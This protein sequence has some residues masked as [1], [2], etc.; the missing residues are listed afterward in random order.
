MSSLHGAVGV[1]DAAGEAETVEV[2]KQ[3]DDDAP[4]AR[5]CPTRLARGERLCQLAESLPCALCRVREQC[6]PRAEV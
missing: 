3:W 5:Q 6:D 4:G 2:L 1:A